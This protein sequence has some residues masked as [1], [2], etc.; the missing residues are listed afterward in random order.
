MCEVC[1][2][3]HP[4]TVN[5]E[6][7]YDPTRTL[8]LRKAFESQ[9]SKRFNLI[10]RLVREAIV[11][12][13]VFGLQPTTMALPNPG[14]F[15][16][17]RSSDKV[18]G[19][20]NWLRLQVQN[21]ILDVTNSNLVGQSI[22]SA[23]TNKYIADS[24][25][26]GLQRARI[27]LTRAGYTGIP[28][29]EQTGGIDVLFNTPANIDRV[30]VL[31]TRV[32]NDLKGITTAM[33]TQ[34]SRVLSQGMIDGDGPRLL[35]SKLN[36]IITGRGETL[37]IT[38]TL[39]RYISPKRRAEM[40]ARTE[41]IRAHHLGTMQEYKTWGVQGVTVKAEWRTAGDSRVCP[42]CQALEGTVHTLEQAQGMIPLHPSCRCMVLPYKV[43][44]KQKPTNVTKEILEETPK[45]YTRSSFRNAQN[46][47]PPTNK[48]Y[49]LSASGGAPGEMFSPFRHFGTRKLTA[50]E[51]SL[52]KG[53]FDEKYVAELKR[54]LRNPNLRLERDSKFYFGLDSAGSQIL[55]NKLE[56]SGTAQLF[57]HRYTALN[58]DRALNYAGF[59][60][61][62]NAA[63]GA[64]FELVARKGQKSI[65]ADVF[66]LSEAIF[67]PGSKLKLI[68]KS[69]KMIV[70]DG[71]TVSVPVY[72]V[73]LI[74]DGVS[75]IENVLEMLGI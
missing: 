55:I 4:L 21:E 61:D 66:D 72:K 17:P 50:D 64:V 36:K 8:T 47:I 35:A 56:Q 44:A 19:F 43:S 25:K 70:K 59:G 53:M 31:Y 7:Q 32:F 39:G 38:D 45:A 41:I 12:R 62:S 33:D 60:K 37:G 67:L 10:A 75:Y 27:E 6:V 63:Q 26:R 14:A 46:F 28:N 2:T 51:V 49:P 13:D 71:R 9:M 29:I 54:I 5:A 69:T 11:D 15:N 23:W 3:Y 52:A 34:I 68:S 74:D 42:Q 57:G 48:N 24:Y 65:F 58:M 1:T 22:D 18:A 16:F 30:G 73:E 20:M 40:L